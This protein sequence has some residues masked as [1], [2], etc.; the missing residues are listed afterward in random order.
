MIVDDYFFS[1]RIF[2]YYWLSYQKKEE[3]VEPTSSLE[4]IFLTLTRDEVTSGKEF[5]FHINHVS[6]LLKES[7]FFKNVDP[8]VSFRQQPSLASKLIINISSHKH[9]TPVRCGERACKICKFLYTEKEWTSNNNITLQ[10]GRVTCSSTCTIYI[11]IDK[12]TNV[13][14][15]IGQSCQ[16][17]NT[18]WAQHRKDKSWVREKAKNNSFQIFAFFGPKQAVLRAEK[19]QMLIQQLKPF[20]NKQQNFFWYDGRSHLHHTNSTVQPQ[21]GSSVPQQ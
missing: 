13:P 11:A 17:L 1:R 14:L 18:R 3:L 10:S 16:K 15:Y 12:N 5:N 4:K 2:T 20:Y 7:P 9:K 8:K 6:K 19:E 21:P